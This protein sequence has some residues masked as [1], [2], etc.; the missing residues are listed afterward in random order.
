VKRYFSL[1]FFPASEMPQLGEADAK[2]SGSY[3]EEDVGDPLRRLRCFSD[4]Q[5]K[6]IVYRDWNDPATP[7]ADVRQRGEGVPIRVYSPVE[8]TGQGHTR[9]RTW[10][11]NADGT[12]ASVTGRELDAS[13]KCVREDYF[14]SD[15]QLQSYQEYR[16]HPNGEVAEVVTR[17]P[18]GALLNV[19]Y[20]G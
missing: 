4:H 3:V 12:V 6:W 10:F 9:W 2:E 17:N 20:D 8:R 14:T 13:G 7:I 11:V 15:G 16:Y 19:D 1:P 5:L 18:D